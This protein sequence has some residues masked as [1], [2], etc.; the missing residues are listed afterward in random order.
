MVENNSSDDDY[1][2]ND[3]DQIPKKKGP[4]IKPF[5][6]MKHNSY[7]QHAKIDPHI[8][9]MHEMAEHIGI[10]FDELLMYAGM[11]NSF[12]NDDIQSGNLYKHMYEKGH[13]SVSISERNDVP[14]EKLI[15]Y[16]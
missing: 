2:D 3:T 15:A 11:R 1:D 9:K 10:T 8:E 4:P 13:S 14:T 12:K 16:R 7:S 5:K 6:E